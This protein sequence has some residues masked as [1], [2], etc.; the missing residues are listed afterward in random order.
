VWSKAS[1]LGLR[2]PL[3]TAPTIHS[4]TLL[5]AWTA[6]TSTDEADGSPLCLQR[7]LQAAVKGGNDNDIAGVEDACRSCHAA[8]HADLRNGHLGHRC[9]TSDTS[10][11]SLS[12]EAMA[13]GRVPDLYLPTD[14]DI[15][16]IQDGMRDGEH[17][18]ESMTARSGTCWPRSLRPGSRSAGHGPTRLALAKAVVDHL[19][20]SGWDLAFP[21]G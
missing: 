8:P 1:S 15:P 17:L 7:G 19:V 16:F 6:N 18:R 2:S 5:G 11:R 21:L 9:G 14:C 13:E 4:R 20:G 10:T 12:I 3:R